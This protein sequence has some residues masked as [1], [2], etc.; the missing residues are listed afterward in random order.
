[1]FT[2]FLGPWSLKHF[3]GRWSLSPFWHF[4]RPFSPFSPSSSPLLLILPPPPLSSSPSSSG[5]LFYIGKAILGWFLARW[6]NGFKWHT[7]I[8]L[9]EEEASYASVTQMDIHD[10]WMRVRWGIF[11]GIQ[12]S[13][14]SALLLTAGGRLR[15]TDQ[16]FSVQ[17]RTV[18]SNLGNISRNWT[19]S[20]PCSV[21][22]TFEGTH[23]IRY[24]VQ[25]AACSMQHTVYRIKHTHWRENTH[26]RI[27]FTFSSYQ[28]WLSVSSV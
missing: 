11:S 19:K 22:Y 24:T 17:F 23:E 16:W 26:F 28:S 6:S 2:L 13:N 5:H 4:S 15:P 7:A 12:L 20:W 3:T 27:R 18:R 21:D 25:H 1:M 8:S 14:S 10:G 9:Q